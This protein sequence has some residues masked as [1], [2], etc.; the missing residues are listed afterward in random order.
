MTLN[1]RKRR[2]PDKDLIK[3]TQKIIDKLTDKDDLNEKEQEILDYIDDFISFRILVINGSEKEKL[4]NF[5]SGDSLLKYFDEEEIKALNLNI[6]YKD[7]T[8]K[9]IR[10][11]RGLKQ[12]KKSLSRK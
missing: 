7:I 3:K 8:S 4:R 12:L 9:K 5:N 10:N 2:K 6:L 1:N 11:K